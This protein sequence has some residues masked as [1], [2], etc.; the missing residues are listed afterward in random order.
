MTKQQNHDTLTL[1]YKDLL[2]CE[3]NR[4]MRQIVTDTELMLILK[5]GSMEKAYQCYTYGNH[6]RKSQ[7]TI[8][9]LRALR[10]YH[11]EHIWLDDDEDD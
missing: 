4:N 7:F 10:E 3:I 6:S 8:D 2:A 1:R 9:D 11:K 5:Y